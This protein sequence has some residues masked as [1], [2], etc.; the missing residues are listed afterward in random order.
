MYGT[1]RTFNIKNEINTPSPEFNHNI[2][3]TSLYHIKEKLNKIDKTLH[4][5]FW[6]KLLRWIG[7]NFFTIILL[8]TVIILAYKAWDMYQDLLVRIEEAK[9]MPTNA[10]ETGKDTIQN[11]IEKVKFW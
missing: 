10:V 2:I 4:P 6:L 3:I 8:I 11:V 9:N 1:K 7:R 5:P